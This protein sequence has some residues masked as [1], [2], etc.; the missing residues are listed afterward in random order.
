MLRC[1]N[2][3]GLVI[4]IGRGNNLKWVHLQTYDKEGGPL[5]CRKAEP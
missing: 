3:G 2:C 5:N 4:F 1:K